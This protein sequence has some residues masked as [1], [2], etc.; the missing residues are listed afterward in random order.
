MPLVRSATGDQASLNFTPCECGL[1]FPRLG[2]LDGRTA[3]VVVRPDGA[4]V[5]GLM[6]SDLFMD[7]PTLRFAQF[8][9]Q[10]NGALDVNVVATETLSAE[11]RNEIEHE[12]RTLVGEQMPVQIIQLP[13]IE[14]NP[15]SGKFQEVINKM[16]PRSGGSPV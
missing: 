10:E 4:S 16:K 7:H 12:V 11:G 9:Q 15:R 13:E 2:H 14:R 1:P 8:V 5:M 6:L 3:D